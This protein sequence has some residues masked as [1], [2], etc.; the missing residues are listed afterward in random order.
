MKDIKV[1]IGANFG[2]EGKG[3]L[4]NYF[5][6]Q[7]RNQGKKSIVVMSNGGS[8]RGHTVDI[9]NNTKH[10]FKHFGSGT[11]AGADTL[12][13][14]YYIINP[15]NFRKEF[16]ELKVLMANPTVFCDY[17]C[18]WSTPYD[19]L[20]NQIV[21]QCRGD[22]KHG[23]CGVGIWETEYRYSIKPTYL[24]IVQFNNLSDDKKR[25]ILID[26]RDGYFTDRLRELGV[27]SV[28]NDWVDVFY[29]ENLISNFI[30]DVKFF[31]NATVNCTDSVLNLYDSIVF[32]NGQGLLLD[33]SLTDMYGDNLTPSNT[34][35][36]NSVD[37]ISSSIRGESSV[38]LCY[39]SRSYMTRHGVGRFVTECDSGLVLKGISDS[40]T[41][42]T[43]EFQGKLRYGE[44]LEDNL[45][46]R[47]I[48]DSRASEVLNNVRT[49][50][51]ITHSN[52][53]QIDLDRLKFGGVS[54][55]YSS[56]TKFSSSIKII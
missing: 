37:I 28:P 24:N 32:E 31:V 23:S 1:V 49:S 9:D 33:Q 39:V 16:L 17:R 7:A 19:M 4:T 21:E 53:K 42:K 30:E 52:E 18:K 13:S 26:L 5:C 36:A 44:L 34:G 40:E 10:I 38:E 2:D 46:K 22:K 15:M 12:F 54:T 25:N 48:T 20:V 29:S 56:D 27:T 43:N 8:Q 51:C 11:L 47:V 45:S 50:L 14:K 41:N 6:E 55:V 3:L 35:C